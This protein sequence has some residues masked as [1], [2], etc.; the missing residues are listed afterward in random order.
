MNEP[1][2]VERAS[3]AL[4]LGVVA[5]VAVAVAIAVLILRNNSTSSADD[6]ASRIEAANPAIDGDETAGLRWSAVDLP[7]TVIRQAYFDGEDIVLAGVTTTEPRRL[8]LHMSSDGRAWKT[9]II[10]TSQAAP[11]LVPGTIFGINARD[12]ILVLRA[13]F[14]EPS[15]LSLAESIPQ[16]IIARGGDGPWVVSDPTTWLELPQRDNLSHRNTVQ[17]SVPWQGSLFT[18][19]RSLA[20]IDVRGQVAEQFEDAAVCVHDVNNCIAGLTWAQARAQLRDAPLDPEVQDLLDN[21][22]QWHVLRSP[23]LG[24]TWE[25][26]N[27]PNARALNME[28]EADPVGVVISTS[29][30]RDPGFFEWRSDGAWVSVDLPGGIQAIDNMDDIDGHVVAWGFNTTTQL[31]QGVRR[32][33]DGG[34]VLLEA[35]PGDALTSVSFGPAGTIYESDRSVE[36]EPGAW[37]SYPEVVYRPNGGSWVAGP[38]LTMLGDDALRLRY[39]VGTDIIIALQPIIRGS[40][41]PVTYSELLATASPTLQDY[42]DLDRFEARAIWLLEPLS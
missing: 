33:E 19:I 3:P 40:G 8:Q 7:D 37:A 11:G 23:D 13:E 38:R 36:I 16:R 34:W 41:P 22:S 10:D 18:L 14:F 1:S 31:R 2:D 42:L 27:P 6:L 9:D 35:R 39:F 24:Q 29:L 15:A 17:K 21:T 26:L 4:V 30:G 20:I 5:M 32:T 25:S 12:D 28:L